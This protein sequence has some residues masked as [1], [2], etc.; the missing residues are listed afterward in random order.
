MGVD[1]VMFSVDW[2]FENVREGSQWIDSAEIS[3]ADRIKVGRA[4]A[5]KLFRLPL[6]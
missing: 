5:I 6:R 2:P 4:N 1:R 3:E